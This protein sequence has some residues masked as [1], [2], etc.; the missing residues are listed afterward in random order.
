MAASDQIK[1]EYVQALVVLGESKYAISTASG[2]L[3]ASKEAA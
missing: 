2:V 3:P 1:S